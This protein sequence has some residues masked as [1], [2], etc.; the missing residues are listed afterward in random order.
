MAR[1]TVHLHG[2]PKDRALRMVIEEHAKRLSGRGIKLLF[3]EE[4]SS[5]DFE[6]KLL[7]LNGNLILLDES[8]T[9]MDSMEFSKLI[10]EVSLASS[11][12]EFAVA[13]ADGFSEEM[14]Q[15]SNSLLSLS[16]MTM[17][18]E[19]AA[20]VLME[21]LYRASEINRGSPYHRQKRE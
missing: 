16:K 11:D 14:R 3:H 10:S 18:H 13:S 4:K 7:K 2:R 5:D 20:A 12:I 8:G 19:L 15:N 17:P 6:D 1:I 21:Q 9:S